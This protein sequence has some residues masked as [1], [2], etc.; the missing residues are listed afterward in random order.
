MLSVLDRDE[1]R[2]GAGRD[3]EV[4]ALF[5]AQAAL[6]IQ[7][8]TAFADAGGVLLAALAEA[9]AGNTSLSDTLTSAAVDRAQS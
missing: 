2:P 6:A 4:A 1:A 3:L 8:S 9:A 7:A 5:A